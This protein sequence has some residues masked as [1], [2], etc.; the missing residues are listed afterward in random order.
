MAFGYA[1]YFTERDRNRVIRWDPDS[2]DADVVAGEPADGDPTQRLSSPYSVC[3]DKD[4]QLL[5]ADKLNGRI[6]RVRAG[7]LETLVLRDAD[8]HRRPVPGSSQQGYNG[9]L[10]G[11]AGLFLEK[12]GTL[13]CSFSDDHT[14]YRI[15]PDLRLELVL[16]VVRNQ[17]YN[18]GRAEEAVPPAEVSKT[19]IDSPVG[20][21]ARTDGTLFFVERGRQAVREYLPE[22]GL[23]TVF[24]F[25]KYRESLAMSR[26]PA[27]AAVAD[28]YPPSPA[29]LAL[30]AS[31]TLY[32][33]EMRHAAILAVDLSRGR[34]RCVAETPSPRRTIVLGMGGL[35]FG[36]D[37]TAWVVDADK[38]KISAY[39]PL[40]GAPWVHRGIELMSVRGT[41]LRF[42]SGGTGIVTGL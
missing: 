29:A 30:D 23:R 11:P 17:P 7:R 19:P 41:P 27:D 33:A 18:F 10:L 32:V 36:P 5:V 28:Y 20:L 24:P 40:S 13:L 34:V 39:V 37:G 1:L 22:S 8:G 2:G 35:A 16:G 6:V 21:V 14:L 42:P 26:A 31:E 3:F 9:E 15:H 4:G 38:G 25:S 12:G